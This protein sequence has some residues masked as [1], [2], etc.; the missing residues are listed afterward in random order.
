MKLLVTGSTR[1][2]S[3]FVSKTLRV[4]GLNVAWETCWR[5]E[6]FLGWG[7]YDGEVSCMAAPHLDTIDPD[8]VQVIHLVREPLA[9]MNSMIGRYLFPD[10]YADNAWRA[11]LRRQFPEAFVLET[12][13][14]R[15][16][17]LWLRWNEKVEPYADDLLRVEDWGTSKVN[18]NEGRS[19]HTWDEIPRALRDEVIAKAEEYGYPPP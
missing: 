17:T 2:G 3:K 11:W 19:T 9:V 4:S 10:E 5:L 12:D 16:A 6:G 15:A 13:L 18:S 8:E 14:E 7:N 1:S